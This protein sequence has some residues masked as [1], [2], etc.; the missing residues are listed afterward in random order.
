MIKVKICGITN[1]EDAMAAAEAG[2]DA[3]GFVFAKS[4]RRITPEEATPIIKRLPS[5]VKTVGVFVNEEPARVR[6]IAHSLQLDLL[7]LH[8]NETPDYCLQFEYPVIK[9]FRIKEKED[10]ARIGTYK[11]A[12]YLLDSYSEGVYG[13]T[14]KKF[15]WQLA[16]EA[17][18]FGPVILAGGLDP[19]NA[20][21][22]IKEVAPYGVDVSSGVEVR[23]G[24]KDADKIR[25]FIRTAKSASIAEEIIPRINTNSSQINTN[26][27]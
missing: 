27:L 6:E 21:R 22:A 2:C 4:P 3:L 18:E 25:A 15:D 5:S 1:L 14:S 10:L 7:Q 26:I 23:P 19:S 17:K 24:K 13:G 8:G 16:R 9:A 11:A 12:A 20:A